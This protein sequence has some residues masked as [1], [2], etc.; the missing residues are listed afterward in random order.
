MINVEAFRGAIRKG[1]WKLVKSLCFPARPSCL[2]YRRTLASGNVADDFPEIAADLEARLLVYAKEKK[3]SEW[4]KA[5]PTFLGARGKTI[6]DPDST[7]TMGV[8]HMKNRCCLQAE[9]TVWGRWAT[10]LISLLLALSGPSR[11]SSSGLLLTQSGR[12]E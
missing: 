4:I 12:R 11:P 2:I 10:E 3:P 9:D 1:N 5:Q 7:S 8:C 6:F